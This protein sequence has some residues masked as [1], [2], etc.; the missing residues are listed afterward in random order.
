LVGRMRARHGGGGDVC[1]HVRKICQGS[2]CDF[3]S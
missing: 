1:G 3:G 2:V